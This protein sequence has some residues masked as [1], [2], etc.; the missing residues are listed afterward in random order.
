MTLLIKQIYVDGNRE[1]FWRN[2]ENRWGEGQGLSYEKCSHFSREEERKPEEK[3]N[4]NS[5]EPGYQ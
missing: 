2:K 3:K 1:V 5:W 4:S